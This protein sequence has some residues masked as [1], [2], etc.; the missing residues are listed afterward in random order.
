MHI[1]SHSKGRTR[2]AFMLM[3]A[4][5]AFTIFGI[6][7]TSI[8]VALHSTARLS[9]EVIHSQWIKQEAQNLLNE[10]ITG[11]Q[12]GN[13]I[14]RNDLIII[15][16]FTQARILVEPHEAI[17]QDENNLENLYSVSVTIYWD[18]DGTRAEETFSTVHYS[19]MF[20]AQNR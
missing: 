5:L 17:N 1:N 10:V 11:P 16:E 15:D 7:V 8:V 20:T 2:P 14:E 18:N 6:A 13:T 12:D 9:Q 4:L 3:E 19:K